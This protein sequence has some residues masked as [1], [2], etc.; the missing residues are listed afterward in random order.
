MRDI[1]KVAT[2][3]PG[4]RPRLDELEPAAGFLAPQLTLSTL[5]DSAD[6][7]E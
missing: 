3:P 6:G 5:C 2:I 4:E 1:D 7:A